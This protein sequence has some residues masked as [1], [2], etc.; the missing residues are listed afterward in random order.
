MVLIFVSVDIGHWPLDHGDLNVDP[1][2]LEESS[3][4][5]KLSLSTG[6]IEDTEQDPF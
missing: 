1:K 5:D 6:I 4:L 2:L 3:S